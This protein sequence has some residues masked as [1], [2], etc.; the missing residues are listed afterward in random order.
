MR[1]FTPIIFV[2]LFHRWSG[3]LLIVFVG[4]KLLSGY[5]AVGDIGVLNGET[6]ERV[7]FALWVDIPLLFLFISHSCYGLFKILNPYFS[8][9]QHLLFYIMTLLA[10]VLFVLTVIFIYVV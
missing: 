4:L 3:I 10:M 8:K 2:R 5:S 6:A 1:K 9:K 7:H